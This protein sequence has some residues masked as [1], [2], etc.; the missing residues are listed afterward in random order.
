MLDRTK[1]AAITFAAKDYSSVTCLID[2]PGVSVTEGYGGWDVIARPRNVG[3]LNWSGFEPMTMTVP[4]LFDNWHSQESVE[5]D[6]LALEL[7]AGR[8]PGGGGRRQP[9]DIT[10]STP[11]GFGSLVP[12]NFNGETSN[13]VITDIEWGDAL[14]RRSSGHRVRQA[15]TVTVSQHP[16]DGLEELSVARRR[17]AHGRRRT[18]HV[19]KKGESLQSIARAEY[20]TSDRWQDIAIANNIR[21]PR[22]IKAG[23]R[24]K[25]PK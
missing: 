24:L 11:G 2:D 23:R 8:G 19:V 1:N 21:D 6:I 10:M 3:I 12:H 17:N 5:E 9:P 13:W 22:Q 18:T 20:G 15:G 4:V 25:L 16:S 7:L 14:R